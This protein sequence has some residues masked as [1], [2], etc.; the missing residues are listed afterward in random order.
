ML[1][2]TNHANSATFFDYAQQHD[3]AL[4]PLRA[5]TKTP[6]CENGFYD[7]T[8]NAADWHAWRAQGHQLGISACL[9]R[10][11]LIDVDA[12]GDR[13]KAWA[14]FAAWC[15]EIGID[16]PAPYC[17]SPNGGWH[18]AFRCPADFD[19]QKHR[20]HESIKVSHFHPL[21]PGEE[22]RERISIRNRAYNVAPGS[23]FGG[24]PYV[25]ATDAQPPIPYSLKTAPL[26]ALLKR[27]DGGVT[28]PVRDAVGG[29]SHD[30]VRYDQLVWWIGKKVE[31]WR[32]GAEAL[33]NDEWISI[34]KRIKLS[35][36]GED[37]LNAFLA[38]SWEDQHDRVTRRWW[39]TADFKTE[40]ENLATLPALLRQDITWMFGSAFGC[41]QPPACPV[42]LDI[43]AEIL[44]RHRMEREQYEAALLGP[45]PDHPELPIDQA[46]ALNDYWAH[47]PSGKMIYERTGELFSASS[48]DKHIGRV[49]NAMKTEGPG[50]LATTWLSQHRFVKSMGWAPGEPKIIEDR[51]LT[52]DGWIRSRGDR[53]FNRYVPPH[54]DRIEGNVSKWLNHIKAI[55]PG[56]A[57]HIVQWLAHRVQRPGDKVNH[58]L[59]FIGSQG[60]GKDTILK[61]AITAIGSQNFKQITA[62]TFFN[63]EW[64]DYLQS[65]ILRINE[66]HDL[67]G[68]SRYGFYDATKDVITNP[69]EA[70]RI[71]TKHVPQYAAVNVCGVIMTSNHF[72]ALYLAP[73]DRRHFVCV[74][75]RA[76]EEFTPGYW[77][78]INAWLENG[79]NEAVA[80]YLANLDL[81]AFNAK[82][83]PPKTAA[84]HMVVAAGVAPESS[85]LSDV[86]ESMGKP[87]AL[88]LQMVKARTPA[89]SQLRLMFEDAKLRRAIPKRLAECGYVAV[90]N[91]DARDSGGR[92]RMPAGKTTIYARQELSEDARLSAA[93][94]LSATA[95]A[96]PLARLRP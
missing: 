90:T 67:G 30:G 59:V 91:P 65:V 53:T 84:W 89:D 42:Q 33:G 9:S 26:F 52:I 60:I 11:V 63:S 21:A 45:L 85:D 15:T 27:S 46:N 47:L 56:E 12:H 80:H 93:R 66:V 38:M 16:L 86:I 39:N 13:D 54:I 76:Q 35:F 88:T 48:V 32:S 69:P 50:T 2:Y 70:H 87:A 31:R 73:D 20:G 19:P 28:G 78:D 5:D 3:L 43:P 36:P 68:E 29:V 75:T 55:Y 25:L 57:D 95:D 10:V 8:T 14:H 81:T 22:D 41:P 77:D 79:G 71:N 23:A 74:S 51:V 96:P 92:W 7:G 62:K 44:E 24:R 61:P 18:F 72:D 6:A 1:S 58:A 4:F 94:L 82:A 37:G 83:P 34:G 17:H 49:K 40:G 64:N